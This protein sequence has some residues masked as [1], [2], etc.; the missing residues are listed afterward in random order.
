MKNLKGKTAFITGGA[1][2]LGFGIAKACAREG[3]NVVIADLR[4]S[5]LD[6][7]AVIFMKNGWPLL[8]LQL[9]VTDSQAYEKAADKAEARFGNIH[10]LVNNAG[11]SC[12]TGPLYE[13]TYK[14]IELGIKINLWGVINGIK[15]IVP[16]MLKHG[17]DSH[18]VSTASMS[19]L[20]PSGKCDIYNLTKAAV[21]AEMESLAEDLQ[22]SNIGVSVF[23]PGPHNTALGTNSA[24]VTDQLLGTIQKAA[25]PKESSTLP[26]YD[27]SI[28][29][30]PDEAGVRV[31]R[32]IKRGDLYILT[33]SE[34]IPGLKERF[35]AV[36]RAFPEEIPDPRF[37]KEFAFLA[38]NPVF[39]KQTHVP[40][41]KKD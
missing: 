36:Y 33:H 27:N 5:V 13:V 1:S 11:I 9:D 18:I 21:L 7:A 10:L 23:C 17:E 41:L 37:Y 34:F 20:L 24:E 14:E 8:P 2:G 15:T 30:S 28:T 25:E 31:I 40:A 6:Q 35:D 32:G 38:S 29:R 12:A 19:S 3:M 22:G 26:E 4:Q 39:N 16:R